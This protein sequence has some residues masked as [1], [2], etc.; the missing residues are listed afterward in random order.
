MTDGTGTTRGAQVG[1]GHGWAGLHTVPA[2]GARTGP[3]PADPLPNC[4]T[5]DRVTAAPGGLATSDCPHMDGSL[6]LCLLDSLL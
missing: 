4:N 2:A 1:N 6:K 5:D 3:G